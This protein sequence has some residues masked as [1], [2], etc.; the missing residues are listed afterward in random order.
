MH[1]FQ[2]HGLGNRLTWVPAE[3][4]DEDLV[5]KSIKLLSLKMVAWTTV[6]F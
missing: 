1:V 3:E 5:P 4:H 2:S 6:Q